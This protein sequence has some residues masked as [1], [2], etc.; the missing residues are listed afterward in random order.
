MNQ[1]WEDFPVADVRPPSSTHWQLPDNAWFVLLMW[2]AGPRWV[3]STNEQTT[4]EPVRHV[5]EAPDGSLTY[6]DVPFTT[7]DQSGVDDDVD[8][9]LARVGLPPR[10]RG[11]DWYLRT[12]SLRRERIRRIGTRVEASLPSN[13]DGPDYLPAVRAA[14]EL[15]VEEELTRDLLG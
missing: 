6:R 14:M 1:S 13:V 3:V 8:E 11:R 7:V 15:I 5:H 2:A 10:P 4:R 9:D 12:D